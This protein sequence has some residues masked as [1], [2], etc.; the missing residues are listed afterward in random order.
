MTRTVLLCLALAGSLA[1]HADDIKPLAPANDVAPLAP[2]T[3]K[4]DGSAGSGHGRIRMRGQGH[5][6][7][8]GTGS[9]SESVAAIGPGSGSTSTPRGK[10]RNAK[11]TF[12]SGKRIYRFSRKGDGSGSGS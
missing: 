11:P 8:G 5:A 6:A 4:S 2:L 3:P 10:W 7:K 12:G 9:G 1:A